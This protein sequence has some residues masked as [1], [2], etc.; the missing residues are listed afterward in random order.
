MKLSTLFYSP[1][2]VIIDLGLPRYKFMVQVLIGE[3]RGQG[4]RM[5]SRCF[6]DSN[7]DSQASETFIN[8]RYIFACS[9]LRQQLL[10]K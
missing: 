4:V 5:G 9:T 7:T 6:W 8:V 3:N 2:L 10:H 1:H